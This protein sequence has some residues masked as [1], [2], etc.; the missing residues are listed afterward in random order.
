MD[1]ADR[2]GF[3]SSSSSGQALFIHQALLLRAGEKKIGK[4]IPDH[5]GCFILWSAGIFRRSNANGPSLLVNEAAAAALWTWAA[6]LWFTF[7]SFGLQRNSSRHLWD[8]CLK[9]GT[10]ISFYRGFE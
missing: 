4:R 1:S 7:I 3:S 6:T 5:D 2:Q 9:R 8:V 10:S